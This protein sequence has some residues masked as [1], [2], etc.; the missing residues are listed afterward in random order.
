M[1]F[2][3]DQQYPSGRRKPERDE[4]TIDAAAND[5][6]V[7][8]HSPTPAPLL[9][10]SRS[11]GGASRRWLDLAPQLRDAGEIEKRQVDEPCRRLGMGLVGPCDRHVQD[12]CARPLG[13][14]R[15]L[16]HEKPIIREGDA[17]LQLAI[18][19]APDELEAA[20][21]VREGYAESPGEKGI[22]TA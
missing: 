12:P 9:R 18:E 16:H 10:A 3:L 14:D 20:S 15:Q 7:V 21:R 22:E 17:P 13:P 4:A 6:D 2:T 8:V 5:D 1:R 11:G 19:L